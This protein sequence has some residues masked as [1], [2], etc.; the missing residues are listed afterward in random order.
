[1]KAALVANL[2][3]ALA[4]AR[5]LP[6]DGTGPTGPTGPIGPGPSAPEH[7]QSWQPYLVRTSAEIIA[8][9]GMTSMLP[10]PDGLTWAKWAE[11]T[12]FPDPMTH[13]VR[14]NPI[15]SSGPDPRM[16]RTQIGVGEESILDLPASL[17]VVAADVTL[18]TLT[19]F[20]NTQQQV[21]ASV[22]GQAV[23]QGQQFRGTQVIRFEAG[24]SRNQRVDVGTRPA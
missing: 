16:G 2:E 22:N 11:L 19:F 7:P 10:L 15:T 9:G 14:G 5:G 23:G 18:W 21:A 6:D 4:I 12:G 17:T 24:Q 1:M 13:D 8:G 20:G 3:A